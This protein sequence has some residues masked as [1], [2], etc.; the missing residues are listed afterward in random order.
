MFATKKIFQ[1]VFFISTLL[2]TGCQTTDTVKKSGF[3]TTYEG[4]KDGPEDG[5]DKI[6]VAEG[7][8]MNTVLKG[9]NQIIIDPINI[10]FAK[11]AE[12]KGI[13]ALEAVK[14]TKQFEKTIK[15]EL[16]DRYPVVMQPGQGVLRLTIALTDVE[17]SNPTMDSISSIVPF[18]RIFSEASNLATGKHSF[19]GS[20]S[21]EGTLVDASTNKT[22]IAFID[23]RYGDKSISGMTDELNDAKEAF[24]WWAKRLRKSLDKAHGYK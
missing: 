9:Y 5:V 17:P 13:N 21:I 7:V 15:M 23:K 10:W 19:V 2:L 22:L 3:L 14:L 12:Y 18:A 11:D 4:F 24:E 16:A 6:W 1:S 20:A 8:E